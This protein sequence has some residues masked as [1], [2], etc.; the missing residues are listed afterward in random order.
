MP[1]AYLGD[2]QKRRCRFCGR[3]RGPQEK[4]NPFKNEAHAIPEFMGNESLITYEECSACNTFFSGCLESNLSEFINPV[5]TVLGMAGKTGVP[6]YKSDS[7]RVERMGAG[8]FEVAADP[9][10]AAIGL[11]DEIVA[12]RKN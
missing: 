6:K 11:T 7:S 10:A 1:K 3:V 9:S 12:E 2:R 5:R 8:A 4:K